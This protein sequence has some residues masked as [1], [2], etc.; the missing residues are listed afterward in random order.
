MRVVPFDLAL[1]LSEGPSSRSCLEILGVLVHSGGAR[2]RYL[3]GMCGNLSRL[4]WPERWPAPDA[5]GRIDRGDWCG[6]RLWR[7]FT[8][9]QGDIL[10]DNFTCT[11]IERHSGRTV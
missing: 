2:G 11:G 10:S 1:F 4:T 6:A 9:V 7:V 3:V 8:C 5:A